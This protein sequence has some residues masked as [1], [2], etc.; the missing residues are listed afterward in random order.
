MDLKGIY[1]RH[2][3]N[4]SINIWFI[5]V[6]SYLGG[7]F[8]RLY[9]ED[10]FT[11]PQQHIAVEPRIPQPI[12]PEHTHD[13]SEIFLVTQGIGTHVL[14]GRPYTLCPGMVCYIKSS[15]YHLFENVANLNLTNVL[16]RSDSSFTY[17]NNINHLFPT[18]T[19]KN[20]S[21]WLLSKL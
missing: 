16:Y 7:V 15:D 4:K 8:M 21:H 1:M 20:I 18:D 6:T 11:T 13:F 19:E 5:Q 12:F 9:S 14:N 17:L 3:V 2:I 10:F